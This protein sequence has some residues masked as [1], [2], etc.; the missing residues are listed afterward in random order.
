MHNAKKS[1]VR[2]LS[3][4]RAGLKMMRVVAQHQRPCGLMDKALVFGTKDCRFESCQGHAFAEAKK[5]PHSRPLAPFT[6][7]P[8]LASNRPAPRPSFHVADPAAALVRRGA[9]STVAW[10]GPIQACHIVPVGKHQGTCGLVA[11]TSAS[12]AEGRQFDPGQVYASV[13]GTKPPE[14]N[15]WPV[16]DTKQKRLRH[17]RLSV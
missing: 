2:C 1:S 14:K 6:K 11:M 5:R 12:H 8:P 10:L 4:A 13:P 16:Q 15:D 3:P 7:T 17:Q 9:F